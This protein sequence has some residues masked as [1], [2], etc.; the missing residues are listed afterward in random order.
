MPPDILYTITSHLP[1]EGIL[2]ASQVCRHWRSV[3][4]SFP[5]L[6]AR[7]SCRGLPQTIACLQRC[8]SLPVHLRLDGSFLNAAI[9]GIIRQGNKIASLTVTYSSDEAPPLCRL[10]TF[11]R[12]SV[13]RLHI[14]VTRSEV[15]DWELPERPM[16]GVWQDFSSLRELFIFRYRIPIQELTAP[17][18]THLALEDVFRNREDNAVQ[19]ILALLRRCPLLE[20]LLLNHQGS[21]LQDASPDYTP[22]RLPYLHTIE[23]GRYEV[24]SGL[25][26]Y[27]DFTQNVAAGLRMMLQRDVCD[28]APPVVVAT[29][30][31]VLRRVD[32]RC[33][34]I[35]TSPPFELDKGFFTRFEGLQGSLEI[36]L[37]SQELVSNDTLS[38]PGGVFFSHGASIEGVR[39]LH[40]VGFPFDEVEDLGYIC[41]A[42]PNVV[43][44]SFFNCS[45]IIPGLLT[46]NHH[47]SLPFPHLE[48]VVLFGPEAEL[49]QVLGRRKELGVPL[50]TLVIGRGSRDFEYD[51]GDYT[52][53]DDFVDEM[54]AECP[55]EILDWGVGNETEYI[56]ST[57]SDPKCV[58]QIRCPVMLS[59]IGFCS[60]VSMQEAESLSFCQYDGE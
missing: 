47:G 37:S 38:G 25:V 42:M 5:S 26:T 2:F 13:E 32:I 33:I 22:V 43:S 45:E 35:A 48:R 6:W 60:A 52:G 7:I 1:M 53:L 4:T 50:K 58:S 14:S 16:D 49:G 21:L 3:L 39:E 34:T 56:W 36:T 8:K 18:L 55:M 29:I 23:M 44:I 19:S 10:L 28:D 15:S 31:H 40:I 24:L 12:P 20:T 17:N 9:A 27:L 30:Q 41:A 51:W 59:S 11:S 57:A 54:R 46:P